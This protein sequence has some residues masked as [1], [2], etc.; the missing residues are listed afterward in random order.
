MT[1]ATIRPDVHQTLDVHG[2][3]LAQVALDTALLL[4]GLSDAPPFL[5]GKVLHLDGRIDA[6]LLQDAIGAAK[7]NMVYGYM[8]GGPEQKQ[9][10]VEATREKAVARTTKCTCWERYEEFEVDPDLRAGCN[11]H[12]Q[13]TEEGL[14][15][16]NPKITYKLKKAMGWGDPYCEALIE[17]EDE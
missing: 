15:V 9:Q 5:L 2:D 3:V 11:A 16:I 6:A 13:Q 14:K 10:L 12:Q 4:D 17:F 1:H 7:L 8:L